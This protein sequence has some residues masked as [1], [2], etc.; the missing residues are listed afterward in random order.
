MV[1]E[2]SPKRRLPTIS[3]ACIRS[4]D[5]PNRPMKRG[6]GAVRH[7]ARRAFVT[8]RQPELFGPL[9]KVCCNGRIATTMENC[10]RT[11]CQSFSGHGCQPVTRTRTDRSA[12]RNWKSFS[13]TN[14]QRIHL[15]NR[16][17]LASRTRSPPRRLKSRRKKAR[18]PS[19]A[20]CLNS[21]VAEVARLQP[22]NS[23]EFSYPKS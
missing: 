16:L 21:W 20:L 8:R 11:N 22:L 4:P 17:I 2:A 6:N 5:R 1:M 19:A 3:A 9:R 18:R 15:A 12:S 7:E 14:G 10:R 23:C 13:N